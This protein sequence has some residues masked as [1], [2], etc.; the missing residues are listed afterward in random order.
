MKNVNALLYIKKLKLIMRFCIL[1]FSFEFINWIFWYKNK[2]STKKIYSWVMTFLN[3]LFS[4]SIFFV[5]NHFSTQIWNFIQTEWTLF[6]ST[7]EVLF[8]KSQQI[9]CIS[10][11]RHWESWKLSFIKM[12]GN[13]SQNI[14]FS[15]AITKYKNFQC[16]WR[17]KLNSVKKK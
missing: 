2:I 4:L 1:I 6:F 13:Y 14:S 17:C 7:S 16:K 15:L 12:I 3:Q 11:S 5:H 9:D 10:I 8:Y